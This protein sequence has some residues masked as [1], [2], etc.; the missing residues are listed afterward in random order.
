MRDGPTLPLPPLQ[1][2]WNLEDR[3]FTFRL[4]ACQQVV[5]EP[6]DQ[7]TDEDRAAVVRWRRHLGAIAGYRAPDV[8][9]GS[10]PRSGG[11]V[12]LGKSASRGGTDA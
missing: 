8:A 11:R 5:V 4:D 3:G 12:T 6:T 2:A 1:L 7:L 9:D 10:S